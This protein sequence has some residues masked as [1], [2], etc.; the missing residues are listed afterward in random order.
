M[1]TRRIVLTLLVILV[2]A[3]STMAL[4][5][6]NFSVPW[7]QNLSGSGGSTMK[8]TYYTADVTIGQTTIFSSHTD[9]FT[10]IMGYWTA[11]PLGAVFL[12]LITR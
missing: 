10:A 4:T 5:S 6:S 2:L 7:L 12:P 1:K 8:T 9:K 3:G 11:F